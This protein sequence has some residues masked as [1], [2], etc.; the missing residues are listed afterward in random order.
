MQ[1]GVL[2][3]VWE[4]FPRSLDQGEGSVVEILRVRKMGKIGN[5]AWKINLSQKGVPRCIRNRKE[6]SECRQRLPSHYHYRVEGKAEENWR[7]D[8]G[9]AAV[10]SRR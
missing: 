4:T 5:Y 6:R 9:K 2:R 8:D 1:E 3:M 10:W 7:T